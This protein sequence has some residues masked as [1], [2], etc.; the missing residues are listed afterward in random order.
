[1]RIDE[2]LHNRKLWCILL[3]YC[4]EWKIGNQKI[5]ILVVFSFIIFLALATQPTKPYLPCNINLNCC[6]YESTVFPWSS[7]GA[8]GVTN[9]ILVKDLSWSHFLYEWTCLREMLLW[10]NLSSF[11]TDDTF[12]CLLHLWTNRRNFKFSISSCSHKEVVR[13]LFFASCLHVSCMHWNWWLHPFFMAHLSASQLWTKANVLRERTF[14]A[15][16]PWNGRKSELCV[17]LYLFC[18]P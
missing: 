17:F 8:V 10:H 14:I 15:S 16:L 18:F 12:F 7:V 5:C 1:M 11:L 3:H 9:W 4:P 6:T 13:S 2:K